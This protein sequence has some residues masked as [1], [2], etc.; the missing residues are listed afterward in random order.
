MIEGNV[1]TVPFLLGR[2]DSDGIVSSNLQPKELGMFHACV[3]L[4]P[5]VESLLAT[6]AQEQRARRMRSFY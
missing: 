2:V 3:A 4:K 1:L 5:I 6:W